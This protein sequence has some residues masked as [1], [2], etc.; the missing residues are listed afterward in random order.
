VPDRFYHGGKARPGEDI[1][2]FLTR[3]LLREMKRWRS[4]HDIGR[5]TKTADE[6]RLRLC[7]VTEG[8][9]R[10]HIQ[11]ARPISA[12]P[13]SHYD[14][15]LSYASPDQPLAEKV[16]AGLRRKGLRVFFAPRQQGPGT[17]NRPIYVALSAARILVSV[18]TKFAHVDRSWPQYEIDAFHMGHLDD[19][20]ASIIPFVKDI[21]PASLPLPLRSFRA[22]DWTG[23]PFDQAFKQLLK[24]IPKTTTS[25]TT[26]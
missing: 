1:W 15:F 13:I 12:P 6:D 21:D 17:W 14:V 16:F 9:I 8:I 10:R 26:S 5:F 18:A 2:E 7:P 3:V 24:L 23:Q 25:V 22:I 4:E 20:R 19:P 11:L